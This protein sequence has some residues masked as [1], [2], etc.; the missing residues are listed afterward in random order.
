MTIISISKTA[1]EKMQQAALVTAQVLLGV[2]LGCAMWFGLKD[3]LTFTIQ[4]AEPVPAAVKL[5]V[6]ELKAPAYTIDDIP[7][8]LQELLREDYFLRDHWVGT[9]AWD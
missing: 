8:A 1:K 7:E 2:A 3:R 5:Q 6:P 9:I 4:T